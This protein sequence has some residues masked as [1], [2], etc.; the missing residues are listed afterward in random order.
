MLCGY[1]SNPQGM[2]LPAD[3][4][5]ITGQVTVNEAMLTGE[6]TVVAKQ[7]IAQGCFP[8]DAE[9]RNTLFGG[10]IVVQLRVPAQVAA[11]AGVRAVVVRTGFDSVKG[12]LIL[13]ILYPR[14]GKDIRR[15]LGGGWR[16]FHSLLPALSTSIHPMSSIHF[17][18]LLFSAHFEFMH[19]AITFICLLAALALI[20]FI[21]NVK[22]LLD[23]NAGIGKI[24]LRGCDMVCVLWEDCEAHI[25]FNFYLHHVFS[26]CT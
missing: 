18:F 23:A 16:A 13:S 20:G 3:C 4:V 6:A 22:A 21:V 11:S 26:R 2:K 5:L 7:S 14:A 12:R 10:S 15:S 25:C 8:N 24:I 9:P 17:S 1:L 19:Q